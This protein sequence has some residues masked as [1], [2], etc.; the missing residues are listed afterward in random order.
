[1]KVIFTSILVNGII[2]LLEEKTGSVQN[3]EA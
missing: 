1:M 2:G 3:G